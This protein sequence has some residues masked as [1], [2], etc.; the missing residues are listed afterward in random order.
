M[1]KG[2]SRRP[3]EGYH[4]GAARIWPDPP[5]H[6][7]ACG[8][9]PSWCVCT[10]DGLEQDATDRNGAPLTYDETYLANAVHTFTE[11][12][13]EFLR[14]VAQALCK[15][16]GGEIAREDDDISIVRCIDCG[17]AL[18]SGLYIYDANGEDV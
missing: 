12:L 6:C 4:E 13:K 2:H 16:E 5:K 15:H 14:Q 10:D 11:P 1:S 18:P 7:P 9:L 3:G 8:K 17:A